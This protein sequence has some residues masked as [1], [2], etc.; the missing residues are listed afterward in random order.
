MKINLPVSGKAIALDPAAN[1]LSTTD[2]KGRITHVN[3]QFLDISGF[4]ASELIGKSHN[5]IRHPQMPSAAF[6]HLWQTLARGQSWLGLVQ[7]RCKN[8][9]H[10]WV[11]AYVTPVLR[12]GQVVEYQSVRTCPQTAQVQRAE[13]LY[14]ALAAGRGARLIRP[15]RLPLAARLGLLCAL[16]AGLAALALAL[17]G[18]LAWPLALAGGLLL[19]ALPGLIL[20]FALRP[21]QGLLRQARALGHNPL[22]QWVYSGRRDEFGSLAFAMASLRAEADAVVG[23]IAESAQALHQDASELS[24]AVDSSSQAILQQRSDTEQVAGALE[25][26]AASVQDVA[27]NA[28]L[29]AAA[30]SEADQETAAGL[31]LVEQT[32]ERIAQLAAEVD[33]GNQAIQ[34]LAEHSREIDQVLAVIQGIAEQT[35]LLAL[36]AAIEAARAGEAGRGFAV[37]A[38]EVR[39]LAARTQQSTA[40]IQQI[41]ARLQHGTAEA[42]AAMQRSQLGAGSSVEQALQA[43]AALRGISQRINQISEMNLRIA[44][45]VEEQS[46][47][48]EHIQRNLSGLRQSSDSHAAAG[49]Q[50]RS[51]AVHVAG[52]AERMQL[53]VAQFWSRPRRLAD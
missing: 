28:Q 49:S 35:N 3:Q 20:A 11:S 52:L 23:R 38:D 21:L 33:Q 29:S 15:P 34:T 14:Q 9:D 5:I 44:A 43:S 27:R 17:A 6:A 46:H 13:Q 48:G 7:N 30:A 37:V 22:S 19:G 51:N 32:R 39:G 40:E 12:D 26:M 2:L 36:N 1:I 25:Q 24:C 41:I 8:G 31:Q 50:S 45:A 4:S 18:L 16:P 47:A 53:L 10:Y 42:V